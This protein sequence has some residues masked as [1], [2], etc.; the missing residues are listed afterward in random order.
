MRRMSRLGALFL[1]G[2]VVAGLLAPAPASAR[3]LPGDE[4]P[5]DDWL[6]VVNY[7]RATAYLPPVTASDLLSRGAQ[8]HAEYM[9]RND[10]IGHSEDPTRP[11]YTVEGNTAAGSSNV[12]GGSQDATPR[13]MIE[14]WMRGPFHALGIL[15][16][17]LK[18][19]GFGIAH[20]NSGL[21]TAAALDVIRGLEAPGEVDY[22]ISWPGNGTTQPISTYWGG[23]YPDPIAGCGYSGPTGVP[24]IVQFARPVD[25]SA[26]SLTDDHGNG[27]PACQYDGSSYR[28]SNADARELGRLLLAGN[29]AAVVVPRQPLVAG[30]TY[31]FSVT[32]NGV[33]S[34]STFTVT[35]LDGPRL[36]AIRVASDSCRLSV[37]RACRISFS[38]AEPAKVAYRIETLGGTE[39]R[40]V[41]SGEFTPGSHVLKWDKRNA[42]GRKVRA[43]T[44]I[45]ELISTDT[46]G[47]T[48]VARGRLRVTR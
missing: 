10:S 2:L 26:F 43:A 45:Y 18:R 15:R 39:V 28:N 44:Y 36:S 4:P 47:N 1:V 31:T 6:T 32:S 19:V 24:L 11:G 25:V 30:R 13:D 17:G 33:R 38:L 21:K 48:R 22:P 35:D 23:E 40:V 41:Y 46:A 12:A 8:L 42:A 14:V 7:Y 5:A 16:P 20:D 29:N 3:Y 34:E 27:L 9:V 37:A